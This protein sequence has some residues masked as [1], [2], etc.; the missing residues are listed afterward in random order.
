LNK[1]NIQTPLLP[2]AVRATKQGL[3]AFSVSKVK[4]G[5]LEE[6][7]TLARNR[8]SMFI[9]IVGVEYSINVYWTLE[10][11]FANLGMSVRE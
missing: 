7:M 4:A 11:G 1:D 2:P 3:E 10:E 5:K 6:A 9:D 8:M